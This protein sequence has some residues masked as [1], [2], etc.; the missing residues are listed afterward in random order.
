M[1]FNKSF[2]QPAL[3]YTREIA[4]KRLSDLGYKNFSFTGHSYS[5]GASFYFE[6]EDGQKIRVS[7]HRLT[8]N[9]SFEYLQIDIVEKKTMPP[10]I[11]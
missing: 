1:T 9:R 4:E 10:N 2:Y 3:E 11:N 5:N 6:G 7:D 8:G